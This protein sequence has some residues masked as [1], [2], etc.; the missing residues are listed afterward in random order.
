M[1]LHVFAHRKNATTTNPYV[2]YTTPLHLITS[3]FCAICRAEH[4]SDKIGKMQKES[5]DRRNRFR[6]KFTL[7]GVTQS[8]G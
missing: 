2:H 1:A 4:E 5:L 7:R 8:L 6:L 3:Q